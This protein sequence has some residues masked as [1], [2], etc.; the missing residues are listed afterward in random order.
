MNC[1]IF[2]HIKYLIFAYVP[3]ILS[4]I[5]SILATNLPYISNTYL[6]FNTLHYAYTKSPIGVISFFI[7]LGLITYGVYQLIKSYL[8]SKGIKKLQ[9]LYFLIAIILGFS[10][11]LSNF[12]HILVSI[13]ILSAI[14]LFQYIVLSLLMPSFAIVSWT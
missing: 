10:G 5:L 3:R 7:W 4:S 9:I 1:V 2:L 11:G 6:L 13:F 12:F 14:L 8:I